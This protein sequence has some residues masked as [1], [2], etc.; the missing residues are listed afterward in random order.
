[1]FCKRDMVSVWVVLVKV[2][3]PSTFEVLADYTEEL[4]PR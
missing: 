3:V 4:V 2:V 1:M